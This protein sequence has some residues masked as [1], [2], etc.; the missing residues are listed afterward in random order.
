MTA[1]ATRNSPLVWARRVVDVFVTA[2]AWIGG[3]G[4][5]AGLAVVLVDVI[6]RAF[7]HPLS[8]SP[9]IVQMC[10]VVIV[11]GCVPLCERTAGNVRLDLLE[12][13]FPAPLNRVFD[14]I[15]TAL[16]MMLFVL[17]GWKCWEAAQISQMLNLATNVRRIPKA[18]FQI[19]VT[20]ACAIVVCSMLVH[21]FEIA[22]G[23]T[24]ADRKTEEPLT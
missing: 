18:P 23:K 22:V 2:S 21:L 9:D 16:G 8:G 20:V 24:D 1:S 19:G 7:G 13:F 6:G 14:F 5:A 15:A 11:F 4:L 10:Y 17:I 3:A 12:P